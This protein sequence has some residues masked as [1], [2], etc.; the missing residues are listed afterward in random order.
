M[1]EELERVAEGAHAAI[2]EKL[3][4][5][6]GESRCFRMAHLACCSPG[7]SRG[8]TATDL[9]ILKQLFGSTTGKREQ[10][11]EN[12]MAWAKLQYHIRKDSL[13]LQYLE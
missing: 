8:G 11:V 5:F 9:R 3:F 6:P 10:R 13:R 1:E 4:Q 2:S 7:H 12:E